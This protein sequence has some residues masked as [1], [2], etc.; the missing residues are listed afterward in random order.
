VKIVE[1]WHA[2]HPDHEAG[3]LMRNEIVRRAKK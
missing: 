1:A 2:A 3:L